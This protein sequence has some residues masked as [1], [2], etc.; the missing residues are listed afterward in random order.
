MRACRPYP[1]LCRLLSA[2]ALVAWTSYG[3]TQPPSF[4]SD[5]RSARERARIDI[6]GQWVA[7]VTEDW[8][9]RMITPPV[10]ETS[11]IP[12]NPQGLDA[13]AA[14]DLAQDRAQGNLCR[15]YGPPGLIRQPTRIRV[16]WEDDDTLKLDFDAGRQTRR[17]HF[18]SAEVPEER[19]LQGHSSASWYRQQ[20]SRGVLAARTP[21]TGGALHVRTNRLTPGYLRPNG[22][23]YSEQATVGEFF[24]SFTLPGDAGT[25]LIVTT[26]V[27]DPV[28]LATEL[29]MSSQFKKE[30]SR[31]GWNPRPCEIPDP[32]IDRPVFSA[33]PF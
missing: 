15:A 31:S 13:A 14:W 33:D 6:T 27:D 18:D 8:L 12:L 21:L 16:S 7:V 11:S 22:V 4:Q 9:W 17:L 23:P 30:E 3:A 29:V 32:A 25:W 2:A 24:N 26:V 20:Q 19:S 5:A 10:G 1:P 28:Y